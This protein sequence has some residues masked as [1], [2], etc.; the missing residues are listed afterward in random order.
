MTAPHILVVDDEADIRDL[1]KEI[2][3]EEGSGRLLLIEER[4]ETMGPKARVRFL[5]LYAYP[6]APDERQWA[7]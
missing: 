6:V 5:R 2:L 7:R 1:L 3:S 4:V